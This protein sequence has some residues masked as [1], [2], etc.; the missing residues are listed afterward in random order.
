MDVKDSSGFALLENSQLRE[1]QN[2]SNVTQPLMFLQ[3]KISLLSIINSS[4]IYDFLLK[5]RWRLLDL[6]LC[7]SQCPTLVMGAAGKSLLLEKMHPPLLQSPYISNHFS[8]L[9]DH[10]V[11]FLHHITS[12]IS[13]IVCTPMYVGQRSLNKLSYMH[14]P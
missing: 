12:S 6:T 13:F 9:I 1:G 4:V 8:L 14:D 3:L 2:P 7:L 10:S 5:R 11:N